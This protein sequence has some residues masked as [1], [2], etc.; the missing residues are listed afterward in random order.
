[1]RWCR[2]LPPLE[3]QVRWPLPPVPASARGYGAPRRQRQHATGYGRA[4]QA[5]RGRPQPG[6][7]PRGQRFSRHRER[8][9]PHGGCVR[10]GRPTAGHRWQRVAGAT[11]ARSVR[12][13]RFQAAPGRPRQFGL[14]AFH[15]SPVPGGIRSAVTAGGQ[16][17]R[18]MLLAGA[19]RAP[20]FLIVIDGMTAH[21]H[22]EAGKSDCLA[23]RR[24][25]WSRPATLRRPRD[26]PTAPRASIGYDGSA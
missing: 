7:M 20:R 24:P 2:R 5:G 12:G 4:R 1:V 3:A 21:W 16:Q 25:V 13:H 9:R 15:A 19:Q 6:R 18:L 11:L 14:R 26:I 22:G 23:E 17:P 8:S 10:P